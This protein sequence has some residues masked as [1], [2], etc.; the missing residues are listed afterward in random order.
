[1]AIKVPK[2][3]PNAR[4]PHQAITGLS[5][6]ID[7][8]PNW[9]FAR[10][11]P[12]K[13]PDDSL[14]AAAEWCDELWAICDRHFTY[15]LVVEIDA[16]DEL[17]RAMDSELTRLGERLG[18]RGGALRLCGV[19]DDCQRRLHASHSALAS[20]RTRRDAILASDGHESVLNQ[21]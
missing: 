1:M 7:R 20:H 11:D 13:L 9:L 17:P 6:S 16:L 3:K 15:R 12:A 5:C 14:S 2:Q 4:P 19:S 18:E 8:G 21:G 10:V